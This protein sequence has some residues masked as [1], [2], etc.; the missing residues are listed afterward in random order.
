Q[1]AAY[2]QGG[3]SFIMPQGDPS[4]INSIREDQPLTYDPAALQR[5]TSRYRADM[6]AIVLASP[7]YQGTQMGALNV[8]V[9]RAGAVGPEFIK[10]FSVPAHA[11]MSQ[12]VLFGQA[13]AQ[14][15]N[16]LAS[17][18]GN[19]S[20]LSQPVMQSPSQP[21]AQ[22]PV[23]A[24]PMNG[25]MVVRANFSSMQEWIKLKSV[26]ASQNNIRLQRVIALTPQNAVIEL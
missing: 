18:P 2:Q 4:D 12:T 15:Q 5:L 13:A 11:R 1:Q 8:A 25:K 10:N 9:Y 17:L 14:V 24:A 7:E 21:P 6:T 20:P 23:I 19:T 3:P 26:L 22:M 16:I